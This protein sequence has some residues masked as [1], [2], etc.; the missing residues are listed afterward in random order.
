MEIKHQHQEKLQRRC[1]CKENPCQGG[2]VEM[3]RLVSWSEQD[4]LMLQGVEM[5]LLKQQAVSMLM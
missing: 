2:F 5:A 3:S 1:W 4:G